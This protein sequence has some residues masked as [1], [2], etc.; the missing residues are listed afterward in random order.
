MGWTRRFICNVK[1]CNKESKRSGPITTERA[2]AMLN[3]WIQKTQNDWQISP[4]FEEDRARLNLQE[5]GGGL[6]EHRGSQGDFPIPARYK[7]I[8]RESRGRRSQG[9]L[10]WGS[11]LRNDQDTELILDTTIKKACEETV[12]QM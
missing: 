6:L 8:Q 4:K 11:R 9:N 1:R 5:N 2:E 10:A 3:S 7:S 12:P